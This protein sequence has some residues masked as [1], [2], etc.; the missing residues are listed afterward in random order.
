MIG[1]AGNGRQTGRYT[2]QTTLV[3]GTLENPAPSSFQSGLSLISGWVCDA[4]GVTVEI[5]QE[6]GSVVE[7]AAAYGTARG[8]TAVVCGDTDNGFGVLVNWNLVSDGAHTVRALVNGAPFGVQLVPGI[9]LAPAVVDGI[10]LG[11]A[12]VTVTTLGEEFRRGLTGRFVVEDFPRPGAQVHL[13]WH[14]AQQ[15]FVLAP[16]ELGAAL[17]PTPGPG[18]IA[19]VLENP[20]PDSFQSGV[21]VIS[22]WVCEAEEFVIELDGQPLAAAAGTERADTLDLC[23]DAA[24]GFGLLVNWAEF[25][26]GEH[27]VVALVDGAELSRATVTVTVVDAAE[28]FVRGLAKRVALPGFPTAGRDSDRGVA[29]ES[30]ELRHHR[31]GLAQFALGC[32]PAV[33]PASCRPLSGIPASTSLRARG[34]PPALPLSHPCHECGTPAGAWQEEWYA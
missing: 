33:P 19:G 2:L 25:G 32:N 30:A 16:A 6:D 11:R 8:D 23:G 3:L 29:G 22:G 17:A 13:V 5:E 20:A 31:R 28:P 15:N 9:G 4:E 7:L 10:E 26:A 1:V 27:E 21:G 12:P 18:A 24:N 14:E 34:R